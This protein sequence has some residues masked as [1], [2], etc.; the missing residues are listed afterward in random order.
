MRFRRLLSFLLLALV[1]ALPAC[2]S[3]QA[4][5]DALVPAVQSA[6]T[7]VV[8]DIDRGI[9]TG[10]DTGDLTAEAALNLHENAATLQDRIELG[11]VTDID[12]LAWR[13][14][15][16][17]WALIGIDDRLADGEIS[18][19]VAASFRERIVRMDESLELLA[20]GTGGDA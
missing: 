16:K 2:I 6:W 20:R 3:H 13:T 8:W 9:Q 12:L 1:C 18:P 5:E 7:S 14:M 11:D 15:L 4:R 17:H 19:G 10:V